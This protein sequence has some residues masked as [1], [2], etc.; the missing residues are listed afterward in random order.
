MSTPSEIEF[1]ATVRNLAA[2][3]L[4]FDRFHLVRLLGRGGMGLVWLARDQALDLEVALKFLPEA[5]GLDDAAV[6]DLARETRRARELAHH[7]IVRV[8]DFH[9]DEHLAAIS[10]E[11]VDGSTLTRS[12]L[13][14]PAEVFE[15][16]DLLPWVEQLVDA[17]DY[18]HNT[19][20]IVHRDLKPSNLLVNRKGDLK[21]SD[22][23]ISASV[24]DSVTRLS[25]AASSSG[26]PPYMSPQQMLGRTPAATDDVYSLGATLYE[27]LTGKAPFHSGNIPLQVQS[28]VPPPLRDRRRELGVQGRAI[29]DTWET[30][31]AACLAKEPEARPSSMKRVLAALRGEVPV[32]VETPAMSTEPEQP[33]VDPGLTSAQTLVF[34]RASSALEPPSPVATPVPDSGSD[35]VAPAD[36]AAPRS[37]PPRRKRR[38]AWLAT[39][40]GGAASAALLAYF[41]FGTDSR[42]TEESPRS[43]ADPAPVATNGTRTDGTN[44]P[45]TPSAH[46]PRSPVPA[47]P[48]SLRIDPADAP[49]VQVWIGRSGA[50]RPEGGLVRVPQLE[51]G[52]HEV[53][54]QAEGFQ[55]VFTRLAV[56][57]GKREQEVRLVPLRGRL[58]LETTPGTQVVATRD[59]GR[60]TPLGRADEEG[61]L[62]SENQLQV[63]RYTLR[64]EAPLRLPIEVP[65]SV[66]VGRTAR[67]RQMLAPE[68]GRLRIVS[69]PVGA[70]ILIDGERMGTT[71]LSLDDV[72]VETRLHV[73]AERTGYRSAET[74]VTLG[75]GEV[76]TVNLGTLVAESG[77]IEI[78]FAGNG[79]PPSAAG[80]EISL[81]SRRVRASVVDGVWR[82][83]SIE[84]GEHL[85]EVRR[86]DH[87]PWTSRVAVEDART[88]VI[89][90][91]LAPLP[92]FVSL[93]V[94]GAKSFSALLDGR[95]VE[96]V[97]G[98]VS[99]P[100]DRETTLVLRAPGAVDAVRSFK[101]AP[102]TRVPWRA[103]LRIP[104]PTTGEPW[105]IP[106]LGLAMI[107]APPGSFDMG[108]PAGETGR[109]ADEGPITRVHFS[110]GFWIGKGEVTQGEWTTLMGNNPSAFAG[111]GT[112]AP[113]EQ[114]SWVDAMEFCRRLTERERAAGRLPEGLVYTLPTEAQWE[115][116]CRAGTRTPFA[117]GAALSTTSARFGQL[118]T[119][120][121]D[122]PATDNGTTR[123][124]GS[125]DANPWGLYDMHG[126][127]WEWCLDRH[128]A[129]LPGGQVDDPTGPARGAYM[130]VRGGGWTSTALEC[131]SANRLPFAP[132]HAWDDVGFRLVLSSER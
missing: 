34:T 23:G 1:G 126:N 58:E 62:T 101:L 18:A 86:A 16:A 87:Q 4:V 130:V 94:E 72:A 119:A 114:V 21:V 15:P 7:H 112:R 73:R 22:F 56:A 98:E 84:V 61:F 116:A 125:Y 123:R 111:L 9:R 52:D 128:A 129:S 70:V 89:E 120:E 54:V 76:R 50:L 3:V 95:P 33:P 37:A 93:E 121:G 69:V 106:E 26:S 5:V 88:T 113:V 27:L 44:A 102:A 39:I 115:Y 49:G 12:R 31:I 90:A 38:A 32:V 91:R 80:L 124:T 97:D 59:D 57:E 43:Q 78:R 68:P 2:G 19:A 104:R 108:S 77:T 75:P 99:I 60:V 131:R 48:F 46:E 79:P 109:D 107:W 64:L 42:S 127:V 122:E 81:D 96:V 65:L 117:F 36:V 6:A 51:D 10:M 13:E 105:T 83:E 20:E 24:S 55:P 8:Y 41:V 63:G 28:V 29:P 85:L 40:F 66:E 132:R 11:F 74:E 35:L 47:R 14:K 118:H 110:D 45:S 53:V 71:P 100:P 30:T 25:R 103:E 67:I 82:L 17:L 92:A